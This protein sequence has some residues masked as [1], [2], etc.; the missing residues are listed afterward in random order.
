MRA[1]SDRSGWLREEPGHPCGSE[2]RQSMKAEWA[3]EQFMGRSSPHS[4]YFTIKFER[5]TPVRGEEIE[6]LEHC[7]ERSH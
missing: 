6:L 7:R 4:F 2:G 1:T 5:K 3:S